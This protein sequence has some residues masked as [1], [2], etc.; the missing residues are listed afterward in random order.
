MKEND[1]VVLHISD[2]KSLEKSEMLDRLS[3]GSIFAIE[4][5]DG[6]KAVEIYECCDGYFGMT[7]NKAEFL[8]LIGDLQKIADKM[9]D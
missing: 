2:K 7:L 3:N 4:L 1:D 8:E 5:W 9:E 6:K